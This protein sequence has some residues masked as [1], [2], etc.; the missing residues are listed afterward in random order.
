M[1]NIEVLD[2]GSS[3]LRFGAPGIEVPQTIQCLSGINFSGNCIGY[4]PVVKC[5]SKLNLLHCFVQDVYPVIMSGEPTSK[6]FLG[7]MMI[8]VQERDGINDGNWFMTNSKTNSKLMIH[9]LTENLF[10]EIGA[11]KMFISPQGALPLYSLGMT[12]GFVMDV[13]KDLTS[14]VPC[15][16]GHPLLNF[17]ENSEVAGDYINEKGISLLEKLPEYSS[18]ERYTWN[19]E[20]EKLKTLSKIKCDDNA[21]DKNKKYYYQLFNMEVPGH[22][23]VITRELKWSIPEILFKDDPS[24]E[25]RSL[26]RQCVD[27]IKKTENIDFMLNNIVVT[28]GTTL[29]KNFKKRFD[30]EIRLIAGKHIN[31][32]ETP[33]PRNAT[34]KGGCI[35]SSMSSFK[36]K[37]VTRSEYEEYGKNI[38]F[39]KCK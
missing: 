13:G 3:F 28:G 27:V 22:E 26:Q 36:D 30:K 7:E 37:W 31:V 21:K 14:F 19:D 8:E 5:G 4:L 16:D 32:R 18:Y 10:E 6:E 15:V 9:L 35:L 38:V 11:N 2:C 34:W 23:V 39:K 29:F 1:E 25:I 24:N 12:D 20:M 33:N 17:A